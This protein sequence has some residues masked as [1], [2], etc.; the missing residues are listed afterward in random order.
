MLEHELPV[1]DQAA[2]CWLRR[3][4]A[5]DAVWDALL[6]IAF[7]LAPWPRFADAIGLPAAQPWPAFEIV[8]LG[9]FVF[10]GL[11]V[12]AARG[13]DTV[14]IARAAAIG[15]T[16]V[17]ILGIAALALLEPLS[18]T[19]AFTLVLVTSVCALFAGLEFQHHARPRG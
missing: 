19:G 12:R 9:C 18:S 8:G 5:A 13:S 10:S 1:S 17:A 14:L 6:G 16:A 4:C 15:N 7:C 2:L 3:I 11:L